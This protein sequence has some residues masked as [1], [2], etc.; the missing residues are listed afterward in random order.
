M[1]HSQHT[2]GSNKIKLR[3][4]YRQVY[5]Q[6]G[7]DGAL[8]KIFEVIGLTNKYFV[9]FGSYGTMD[10]MGN[11]P[12]LRERLGMGGPNNELLMDGQVHNGPF[13]VHTHIV[14][15]ANVNDLFAK[16]NVPDSFDFLSIDIDG[17]DWHVWRALS[18]KY[19][20]RVVSIECSPHYDVDVDTVQPD[21]LN[22][23]SPELYG[24][25]S[26]LAAT[27]LALT[28]K[29]SLV[30]Y[31]G[32]DALF[33]ADEELSKNNVEFEHQNDV[34]KICYRLYEQISPKYPTSTE[35]LQ[36]S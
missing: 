21:N 6:F 25:C 22:F 30:G 7:Q 34:A 26:A 35:Y 23:G 14:T 33:V 31:C 19:R 32:V 8:E 11:T 29:Y 18:D 3:D 4:Y 10:G 27:R 13:L 1:T 17:N 16:Y 24:G 36:R 9:E 2:H 28:K 20:P 15:S 12:F 5:S